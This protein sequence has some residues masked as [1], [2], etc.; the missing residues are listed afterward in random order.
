M[1]TFLIYRDKSAPDSGA[2]RN[3]SGIHSVLVNGADEAAARDAA[4]AGRPTGETTI[5][6][7][8]AAVQIASTELPAGFSPTYFEGDA[9][10]GG[11]RTRG[12]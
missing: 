12:G 7:S 2:A 10:P 11:T 3:S 9:L 6:S 4:K 1:A 8:W 5:H